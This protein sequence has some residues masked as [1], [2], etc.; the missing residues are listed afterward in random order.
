[1]YLLYKLRLV[2]PVVDKLKS[3]PHIIP[4]GSGPRLGVT[5]LEAGPAP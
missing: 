5:T 4:L 1:M 2:R 3:K